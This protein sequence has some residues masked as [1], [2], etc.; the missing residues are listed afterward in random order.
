MTNSNRV[1]LYAAIIFCALGLCSK[2]AHAVTEVSTAI[3]TT[4][5]TIQFPSETLNG[6]ITE[7]V[8]FYNPGTTVSGGPLTICIPDGLGGCSTADFVPDV[9]G[10]ATECYLTYCGGPCN[11]SLTSLAAGTLCWVNVDYTQNTFSPA[12]GVLQVSGFIGSFNITLNAAPA[13]GNVTSAELLLQT[14]SETFPNAV[15]SD[16]AGNG[17]YGDNDPTVCNYS[18]DT[19]SD[20]CWNPLEIGFDASDIY[21]STTT[22]QQA[23][24]ASLTQPSTPSLN[25]LNLTN[26]IE[27]TDGGV[28][29]VVASF[30]CD[31]TPQLVG[32]IVVTD[33]DGGVFTYAVSPG[34]SCTFP[35]TINFSFTSSG[36]ASGGDSG[37][38]VL[39]TYQNS[40]LAGTYTGN[41]DDAG[42]GISPISQSGTGSSTITLTLAND[43]T[44]T[45]SATLP[46]GSLGTCQ[47]S[48]ETFTTAQALSL[49]QGITSTV[50]GYGTAGILAATV[51]DPDGDVLWLLGSTTDASGHQLTPGQLFFSTYVA[52]AG[53][54][55][56]GCPG[57]ISWDAPFQKRSARTK[58]VFHP[59]R[60]F[61]SLIPAKWHGH[62]AFEH[63]FDWNEDR[64]SWR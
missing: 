15:P 54:G 43:F 51:A 29:S 44:M 56:S 60:H 36:G 5:N 42:T 13:T 50:G 25:L 53:S 22:P 64:K 52:V 61:R 2:S 9:S 17:L 26:S 30:G 31:T 59:R 45:G 57:S 12:N 58:P 48:S 16:T 3:Q 11:S 55:L 41:W 46:A 32:S 23:A 6:G 39:Y 10:G 27:S 8:E 35:A 24:L 28:G 20:P 18:T 4:N 33:E 62:G 19:T 14:V 63:T 49:G 37:T 47:A 40:E 7:T 21:T 38:A 1:W 34:Q